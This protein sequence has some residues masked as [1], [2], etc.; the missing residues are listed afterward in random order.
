MTTQAASIGTVQWCAPEVLRDESVGGASD[1]YS[2]GVIA[3][4]CSTLRPPYDG[5]PPV[6]LAHRLAYG[7]VK[8]EAPRSAPEWMVSLLER[9]CDFVP[10]KRPT[11]EALARELGACGRHNA[12]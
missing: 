9:S 11:F 1:V 5:V 2:F 3:W 6:A 4:E 7:E 10:S 12:G 8:L